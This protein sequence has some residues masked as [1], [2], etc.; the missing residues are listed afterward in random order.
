M[1][2]YLVLYPTAFYYALAPIRQSFRYV[3]ILITT[4]NHYSK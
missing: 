1:E 2:K 3:F 4:A